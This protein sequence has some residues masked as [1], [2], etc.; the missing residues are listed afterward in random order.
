MHKL[1]QKRKDV[2]KMRISSRR[3][4]SLRKKVVHTRSFPASGPISCLSLSE[5][6][7]QGT[8]SIKHGNGNWIKALGVAVKVKSY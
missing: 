7:T 3:K 1:V 2:V 4:N 8:S 5:L 6:L